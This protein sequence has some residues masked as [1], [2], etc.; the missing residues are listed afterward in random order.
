LPPP[1]AK[2]SIHEK[3]QSVVGRPVKSDDT[4]PVRAVFEQTENRHAVSAP[5]TCMQPAVLSVRSDDRR[6]TPHSLFIIRPAQTELPFRP[7]A[8]AVSGRDDLVHRLRDLGRNTRRQDLWAPAGSAARS[9]S[10]SPQLLFPALVADELNIRTAENN[11][12]KMAEF[13]LNITFSPLNFLE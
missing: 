2:T 5:S 9:G 11:I 3:N 4:A 7:F 1:A 12:D 6:S 8:A 10:S 13:F